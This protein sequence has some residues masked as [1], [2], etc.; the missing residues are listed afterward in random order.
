MFNY[1][2]NLQCPTPEM[3]SLVAIYL[4]YLDVLRFCVKDYCSTYLYAQLGVELQHLF[5]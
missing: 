2:F 1:S 3:C 4:P 5:Y